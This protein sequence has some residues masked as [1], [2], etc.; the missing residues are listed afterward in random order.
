MTAVKTMLRCFHICGEAMT[1]IESR[2]GFQTARPA[3]TPTPASPSRGE[4]K[5]EGRKKEVND[6]DLSSSAG[7]FCKIAEI[8]RSWVRARSRKK[9]CDAR[10]LGRM[11][12]SG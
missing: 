10:W 2:L 8:S 1:S 11:K 4:V 5:K 7:Y 3:S 9:P 12:A 6:R